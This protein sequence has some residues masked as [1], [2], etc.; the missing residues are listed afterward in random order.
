MSQPPAILDYE[1]NQRTCKPVLIGITVGW[2]CA[3][4]L[5]VFP[6]LL[7]RGAYRTDGYEIAGFPLTFYRFGGIAGARYVY[8]SA[9]IV[10]IATSLAI[11]LAG[12]YVSHLLSRARR[13]ARLRER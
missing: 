6:Y 11:A 8:P 12:G 9:I 1:T 3:V 7:S 4:V 2:C 10:D 5:N 13:H